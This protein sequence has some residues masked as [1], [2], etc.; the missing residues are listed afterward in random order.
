VVDDEEEIRDLMRAELLT[1]FERHPFAHISTFGGA[2]PGCA[3]ALSVLDQ[4]EA[5]DFLPR[6]RALGERFERGLM[7]ASF[8]LRRRGMMMGLAFGIPEGGLLAAHLLYARGVFT[9]WANN[10][11]RVL[12]FLPPLITTDD[13]ADELIGILREVFG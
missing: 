2:E 11:T 5:P 13:E 3:A 9:A 6:V 1:F 12:Q 7:G 10:D 8:T 4:I